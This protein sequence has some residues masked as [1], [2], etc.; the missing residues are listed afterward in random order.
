ME[1]EE[2]GDVSDDLLVIHGVAPIKKPEGCSR[3]MYENP[4]GLNNRL[5]GNEKLDKARDIIDELEADVVAYNEHKLNMRHKENKNGFSQMFR[6]GEADIRSVVGHNV[7]ENV[8]RIQQGGTSLLMYGPLIQHLDMDESGA[9]DSGLGRWTVMTLKGD[10]GFTTRIVCAYNPCYNKKQG[11]GTSY[12]QQKRFLITKRKDDT[13]P[14][15]K[16]QEELVAQLKKWREEGDRL[17][18]CMD[19]NEDIYKKSW[20]KILT[21]VDGLNMSEVVGDFTGKK[22]G[23]TH[24][25]GTKPI[26]AMWATTDLTVVS[27]CVMPVGYGIGDHRLFVVDFLTSSLVGSNPPRIVRPE[28]RRLN[29]K[30]E[31]GSEK[32][33]QRLKANV[34]RHRLIERCGETHESSDVKEI[35]QEK[36]NTID[37]ERKQY[38]INAEKKCR[39]I[40]SGRIPYSPQ[41][42]IW[43]RRSQVYRSL[44]KF[45]AGKIHNKSNL[46]RTARRC[47]I[48][49]PMQLSLKEIRLRLRVCKEKCKYFRKHGQRY[50]RKHLNKCLEKARDKADDAAEK[51]ILAIIQR[52]KDRSFWRRLN[53]ALGKHKRSRG[54]RVVHTETP[55]GELVEHNTRQSVQE[56][57]WN[58]IHHKRF[59][60]A[61]GAPICQ[62]NMRGEFG[63][64]AVS[65][66][67]KA[68]LDGT[69]EYPEWFD[70]ATKELCEECARIRLVIPKN[71]VDTTIKREEWQERWKR[72]KEE[73]SSSESGLH[74]SHY[75]AGAECEYI[76]H[77]HALIT[78]I[79]LRRGLALD[80]WSRGLSVMLE[81][82]FGCTL[83]SKLRSILLMEA[84]FNFANKTVYGMR[85]LDNVRKHGFM[86]EE[87]FS[88]KNRMANDGSLAKTLLYDIGR[89]LRVP[90]ALSS[91]DAANCY[92]SIAHA[93][94]SLIFQAFGVPEE[95]VQSMLETIQ[96]MKFFLRTAFGDSK[97][98][99]GS[100]LEVK[101]QGLCQGNGAAPAGWAVIS[102]TILN[103]HKR[104]GH[105]GH[106]ICPISHRRGDLAAILYVDDTDLIHINTASLETVYEAH[107][108]MQRSITNWGNLLIATGG[109]L[110]PGKCFYHLV[111]F[112]WRPDGTWRYDQNELYEEAD[113]VVPLP[114]GS[115]VAIDNLSVDTEKE[116]LGVL[117]CPSGKTTGMN[118]AMKKKAQEWVDEAKNSKLRPSN[119]WFML[120]KQMWPR[121]GYGLCTNTSSFSVLSD[122]LYKQQYQ[123]MPLGGIIRSAKRGIRQTDRGFYG[124]G[125]HHPGVECLVEQA[126]K[127]LMHYGCQSS[128]GL[129]MQMS[130]EL[131]IVEMGISLQPLQESYAKYG[132][133]ITHSWFKSV[134]EKL[135]KFKIVVELNNIPLELPRD[136]DQWLMRLF[137]AAGY[138]K[139]KLKRLNRVRIHQQV[140]FLSCVLG[141]GGKSIDKKYL[142]KR[143]EDERW[144][145]LTFPQERP[146]NKDFKLWKEA[147]MQ[148][149]PAGR[150]NDRLRGFMSI[151]HKIWD[152]RLDE[153]N[154]RVLH[155]KGDV[156]DIYTKSLV[157]GHSRRVN[158][159]TRSRIDQPL[160]EVGDICTVKDVALAVKTVLSSTPCPP[161]PRL[162]EDF[163]DVLID[164]GCTWMWDSLKLVGETDWIAAAIADA[165]LIAVTDGSYIRELYPNVNSA[166]FV[167]VCTKGRGRVLGSFPEQTRSACAYRGELLGLMAIHL[168]LL[169]VNKVEQQLAGKVL[170]YSDCLGA[171]NRVEHLP[172]HRIPTRCRHSD[173]LKNILVNCREM[174]FEMCYSHV[175]AHQDDHKE[176]DDLTLPSKWNCTMDFAAKNEIWKLDVDKLPYQEPFPLEPICMFVGREKMTSDTGEY[177]RFHAHRKL[178]KEFFYDYEV[179]WAEQ[180][181]EVDWTHVYATLHEVPRMFQI[182]ACKQVMNIA[183]TNY[184]QYRYNKDKD[185]L[186]PSC[187]QRYETCEHVI[188][189]EESGRVD[190]LMRTIDLMRDWLRKAGTD[191]GLVQ[192]LVEYAKGRGGKTMVEVCQGMHVRYRKLAESQDCIGWRRFMEGMISKEI[193]PIQSNY[194][195]VRGSHLTIERWS[196]GLITK[197]LEVTHGQWLYRNVQVHDTVSGE[198]ASLR[199]EEIQM[200]IEKQQELGG[201][202]LLEE[203]K[204]LLEVNLDDLENTSGEQ[205]EYWLLAIRA[206]RE[207]RRLRSGLDDV[208]VEATAGMG[209]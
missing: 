105:G 83:V 196:T 67:A 72:A 31:K 59:Y 118:N 132:E 99:A 15:K 173:I 198:L 55:E 169:S 19:A 122:L 47:G 142:K 110:K 62:G 207:A 29:T 54:V 49:R 120:D 144:S 153:E 57:I 131:L 200:E 90:F 134:W 40:K 179:L 18:V 23:A 202:G 113:V 76:S 176:F 189:C 184:T 178:A 100:S 151:G 146:P 92:D 84:D 158:H 34:V 188:M 148:V 9:E 36:I 10:E 190:A 205:Q 111:S 78:S 133:W 39:R 79:S 12:Q 147:L 137:V 7:H 45:H 136:G 22:I 73:T 109:S 48:H 60:L 149:A 108:A 2:I 1:M 97:E 116:T 135:D 192:C 42:S 125:C 203:D 101:F 128:V 117:S 85:M 193:A 104:K 156:M 167:F 164:W 17:V 98:F 201:D 127:L 161:P 24:F 87:I 56:A 159:W 74:F 157:P 166:A 103:A 53:Y 143:R 106:F 64:S 46:K 123:L 38:M 82:M 145:T 165:S 69:Y 51:K 209:I 115:S 114:D 171:L 91:V 107:D 94:A 21:D 88:E 35:V 96:D 30:M 170:I 141:A 63:Y 197:L 66:T 71:S 11:T 185:P 129:K 199:K 121:V 138:S 204:Y 140:L 8:G 180:F 25:R 191:A 13:C 52:E 93:I 70:E 41:S 206:A 208:S 4:D 80:R 95:A 112:N 26:D 61:E 81:K 186:C 139:E 163:M 16:L 177:L 86:P 28:A 3:F 183:G 43:I 58:E 5:S 20:G 44:L 195:N 130:I 174:T 77:L 168:I 27:A 14:R 181:E 154:Q 119:I 194:L 162:P 126:N 75:K 172:P 50:R 150:I 68:I 33:R 175:E 89:Q 65:P 187:H 124:A 32:Y 155:L 6:G 182:W 160:Q 102:I 37:A 152:W